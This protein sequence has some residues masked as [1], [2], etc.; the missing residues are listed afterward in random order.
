MPCLALPTSVSL[1]VDI[2][3]ASHL[4]SIITMPH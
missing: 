3:A 2:E 1:V 4:A